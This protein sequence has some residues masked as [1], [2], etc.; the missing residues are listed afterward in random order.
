MSIQVLAM[1][2]PRQRFIEKIR[3]SYLEGAFREFMCR[4]ISLRVGK[5]D[6][7][8]KEVHGLLEQVRFMMGPKVI[9]KVRSK[10]DALREALAEAM[11]SSASCANFAKN[12]VV[13]YDG[14]LHKK[15]FALEI[16]PQDEFINMIQEFL[17]EYLH[18]I[19]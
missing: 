8:T 7:W 19:P 1:A 16:N 6:S 5:P 11:I 10:E 14:K 13:G 18:L 3:D 17:P 9:V 15:V 2:Y 12:K 4:Q